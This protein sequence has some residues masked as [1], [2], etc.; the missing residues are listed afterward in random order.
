MDWVDEHDR[1][2]KRSQFGRDER[3]VERQQDR[4][5]NVL[6]IG[7]YIQLPQWWYPARQVKRT[8]HWELACQYNS[9]ISLKECC[10]RNI[11]RL[12]FGEAFY[13][14]DTEVF[15]WLWHDRERNQEQTNADVVF[16]CLAR[17]QWHTICL[18]PQCWQE[19]PPAPLVWW[20]PLCFASVFFSLS[21]PLS[22]SH[23]LCA[24]CF[25]Q[26]LSFIWLLYWV[27]IAWEIQ[28][29]LESVF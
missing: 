17:E 5:L 11:D 29:L 25:S 8:L 15:C 6:F 28:K 21:L 1:D 9:Q 16:F 18:Y 3:Q 19:Q 7:S 12:C 22:H 4:V 24:S 14:G 2:T 27:R 10:L 26:C 23:S 20:P 13:T